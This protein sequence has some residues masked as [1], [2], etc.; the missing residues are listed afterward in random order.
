MISEKICVQTCSSE[1]KQF[2]PNMFTYINIQLSFSLYVSNYHFCPHTSEFLCW[3][4][5]THIVM[6]MTNHLWV[7]YRM[8]CACSCW[9]YNRQ[10]RP[11]RKMPYTQR[12]LDILRMQLAS[13]QWNAPQGAVSRTYV[14]CFFYNVAPLWMVVQRPKNVCLRRSGG[15]YGFCHNHAPLSP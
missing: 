5:L 13:L 14:V 3:Y 9:A 15:P 6:K 8:L 1:F 12:V 10:P 4:Y 7:W 2:T 11:L